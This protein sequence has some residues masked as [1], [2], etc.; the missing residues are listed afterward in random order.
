MGQ[1]SSHQQERV[2]VQSRSPHNRSVLRNIEYIMDLDPLP[3][4]V[5]L[6]ILSHVPAN[7]LVLHCRSVS[8]R[9]KYLIDSPT[10]WRMKCEQMNNMKELLRVA[11][12]CHNISWPRIFM[13]K[14][15]SRNLVQNP[16]G[17]EQLQHWD[18]RNGG[19]GWAVEN[20]HSDLEGAESQT[21][22]VTSYEWCEKT[23]LIDLVKEGLWEH[24]LDV[25]QPAIC[26]SDWYAGRHDCG[27]VY[28]LNVQLL[29]AD[30][31]AVI[32]EF[33]KSPDPVPQWND[34]KYNQVSHEFRGYGPGVRYVKFVHKGKDSKFWKGWY[35]ARITNSSVTIKCNNIEPCFS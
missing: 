18:V 7:D 17:T 25:H 27:C 28:D 12:M 26:V 1:Q 33:A 13:N 14:P 32:K 19:D 9:W 29:A 6:L 16:C 15:F 2:S 4:D 31:M 8:H 5:L 35:G 21:C 22:F 10:V 23:Q 11:D 34:K 20:N 3:D 30:K 24:F